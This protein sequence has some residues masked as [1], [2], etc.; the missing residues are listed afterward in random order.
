MNKSRL[1]LQGGDVD[2]MEN[3]RGKNES[4]DYEETLVISEIKSTDVPRMTGMNLHNPRRVISPNQAVNLSAGIIGRNG[5]EGK[6]LFD[7]R[8][9]KKKTNLSREFRTENHNRSNN[10]TLEDLYISVKTTLHYHASRV[11]ILVGTW[12]QNAWKQVRSVV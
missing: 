8:S 6:A 1:R 11:S 4:M 12:F 7:D 2:Q 10:T 5:H 3:A 9:A